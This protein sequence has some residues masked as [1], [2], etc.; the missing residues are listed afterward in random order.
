MQGADKSTEQWRS[1][2]HLGN[3]SINY[4]SIILLSNLI[5]AQR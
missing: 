4:R 5:N 3:E 1:K 2:T